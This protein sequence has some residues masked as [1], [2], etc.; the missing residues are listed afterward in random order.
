[1][2][3]ETDLGW[4][5]AIGGYQALVWSA[6]RGWAYRVVDIYDPRPRRRCD[7]YHPDRAEALALADEI[8]ALTVAALPS[9]SRGAKD[10]RGLAQPPVSPSWRAAPTRRGRMEAI[11]D[12]H[13]SSE[14]DYGINYHPDGAGLRGVINTPWGD[15]TAA[16]SQSPDDGTWEWALVDAEGRTMTARRSASGVAGRVA[17]LKAVEERW[18]TYAAETPPAT[19]PMGV[20]DFLGEAIADLGVLD[21]WI[22]EILACPRPGDALREL[23]DRLEQTSARLAAALEDSPG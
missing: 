18:D 13:E 20:D 17:I 19:P 8:L 3:T 6:G 5:R 14:A 7:G 22:S 16:V 2:W 1:M 4:R 23:A 12:E 9:A 11:M 21:G 10:L 15:W